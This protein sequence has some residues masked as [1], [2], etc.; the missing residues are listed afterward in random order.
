M[1]TKKLAELGAYLHLAA[2][3]HSNMADTIR[4][5]MPGDP[6][7][8][9][10]EGFDALASQLNEMADLVGD[11]YYDTDYGEDDERRAIVG[12]DR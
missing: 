6:G 12:D 9:L 3:N 8:V 7:R 11:G 5:A 10:G 4:E 2:L 1:P